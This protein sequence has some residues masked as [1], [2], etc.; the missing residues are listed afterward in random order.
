[1]LDS[2]DRRPTLSPQICS[3]VSP[4]QNS[5]FRPFR[6]GTPG[7]PCPGAMPR[8]KIF[9]PFRAKRRLLQEAPA[10]NE[11]DGGF[12]WS[13]APVH[14]KFVPSRKVDA[15]L[16]LAQP[17]ILRTDAQS[18]K[19]LLGC[20][21]LNPTGL[22]RA[23]ADLSPPLLRL[24]QP[25]VTRQFHLRIELEQNGPGSSVDYVAQDRMMEY[26]AQISINTATREGA[27]R[28]EKG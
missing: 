8:A 10:K 25:T 5:I 14:G 9:C 21:A 16:R 13:R 17:C 28:H 24:A 2:G 15:E 27:E 4:L 20:A 12:K 3:P 1:M 7:R 23:A 19:L 11:K 6:A 18:E 22:V 26:I